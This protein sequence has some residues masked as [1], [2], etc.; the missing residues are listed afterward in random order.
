ML[1]MVENN[2]IRLDK[3]DLKLLT[4]LDKNCRTPSTQLAKKIGKSRQA[5]DYRINQLV[6]EGII[7]GFQAS[8]NPHKMGFKLYKIYLKL[9]NLPQK[10]EELF[11]YLKKSGMVYWMGECSG[12]WDLICG[13]FCKNDMDFFNFKNEFMSSF[14]EIIITTRGDSL[15]D[16]KQFQKMYFTNTIS[17]PTVFAGEIMNYQLE[18]IDAKI[19]QEVVNNGR[20]SLVDLSS[21]TKSTIKTIQGHLK[22]LEKKGII[23]QY[24]IGVDLNKIKKELYKAII[25][26]DNYNKENEKKLLN[27]ISNLTQTQYFIRNIWELE[28]ELVVNNYQEYYQIIESLKKEFPY[29]IST[30]DSV[31]MISD[32]WT[33]GFKNLLRYTSSL[34]P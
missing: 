12:N 2:G 16:V 18:E 5:V 21:N 31:L 22:N 7:T 15:I 34:Q 26:I 17:S 19:L 29:M 9:R 30:V 13:I 6:K 11:S 33:P 32:E 10:K 4:E 23:I 20:I 24:R 1:N 25:K 3:A 14:S 28:L 27:Y 8:I